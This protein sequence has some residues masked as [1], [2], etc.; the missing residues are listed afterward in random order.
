MLYFGQYNSKTIIICG[1]IESG[2]TSFSMR[3]CDNKFDNC[4][5]PSFVNEISC[6]TLVL[7]Q[8]K[9]LDLKFIVTN[10]LNDIDDVDCFFVLYDL[11]SYQSFNDAKKI[12]LDLLKEKIDIF[13]I[14]N[15]SDLK[16]IVNK[17]EVDDFS[18][19]YHLYNMNISV[20]NNIGISALMKKFSEIIEEK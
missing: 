17:N 14:G 13:F 6:K 16:C 19:K 18:Q 4:Y 9:K 20:K 12:V 10:N 1:P 3:Y 2:K 5:I 8:D 15:K 11:N 7:G